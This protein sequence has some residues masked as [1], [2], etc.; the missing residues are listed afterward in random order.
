VNPTELEGLRQGL[1]DLA[2]QPRPIRTDVAAAR[3]RGRRVIRTRRAL[4]AGGTALAVGAAVAV[5]AVPEGSVAGHPQPATRVI[6]THANPFVATASFGWLPTG[7]RIVDRES[8]KSQGYSVSAQLVPLHGTVRQAILTV[9]PPGPEPAMGF[10]RGGVPAKAVPAQP[11]NGHPAHWLQ[12]PPPGKGT[13]TGEARLRIQLAAKQWAELEV[14]DIPSSGDVSALLYRIARGIRLGSTPMTF[15]LQLTNLPA[16]FTPAGATVGTEKASSIGW[17]V[18]L[19]FEPGLSVS[20]SVPGLTKRPF[21][22]NTKINGYPAYYVDTAAGTPVHGLPVKP[23]SRSEYL[24]VYGVNGL[25]VCF[26]DSA[27]TVLKRVG[28]VIG[29]FKQTKVFGPAQSRWTDHPLG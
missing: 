29:L 19:S 7:W 22:A 5:W 13:A 17:S 3:T 18:Q 24:C 9:F 16:G 21:P 26:E 1:R 23:K 11:V 10:M 28:G 4:T 27:R 20:A 8:G 2:D 15:P 12:P 6:P 14:N 25:D